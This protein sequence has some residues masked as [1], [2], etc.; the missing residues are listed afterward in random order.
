MRTP[1]LLIL[2]SLLFI[3]AATSDRWENDL[4][5]NGNTVLTWRDFQGKPDPI[6][7]GDAASKV[8]IRAN[9]YKKQK[10]LFYD[11][12]TV[13]HRHESWCKTPSAGLLQHEQVH[14]DIAELY[15]RKTRM[16]ISSLKR[17]GI[18][19]VNVYNSA[20]SEIFNESNRAD[21]QYDLETVHGASRKKQTEWEKSIRIELMLLDRF[22][23][24]NWKH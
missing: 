2:G 10:Q 12:H 11:V 18:R 4:I 9:P 14:F 7:K 8:S 15:A 23:K 22:S 20:I 1:I 24:E 13:F 6:A 5:W 3:S 21:A 16:K 17:Q 19:D